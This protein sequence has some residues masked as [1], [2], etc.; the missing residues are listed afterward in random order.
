LL[1][2]TLCLGEKRDPVWLTFFSETLYI[3]ADCLHGCGAVI[4]CT[5]RGLYRVTCTLGCLTQSS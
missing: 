4:R 5:V 2:T 1:S 3:V